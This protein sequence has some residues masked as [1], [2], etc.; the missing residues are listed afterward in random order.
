MQKIISSEIRDYLC[1]KF[2]KRQLFE[3]IMFQNGHRWE[4]LATSYKIALNANNVSIIEDVFYYYRQHSDSITS[5]IN[6]KAVED[7]FL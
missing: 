7:I 3:N 4:D 5:S 2:F 6:S 1:A